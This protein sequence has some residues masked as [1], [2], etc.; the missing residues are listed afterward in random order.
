MKTSSSRNATLVVA[1][2]VAALCAASNAAAVNLVPNDSFETYSNCPTG[3][4]QMYQAVPWNDPTTGTSD[5]YNACATGAFT[6]GVPANN[7]G[8]Q[9][10]RTGSGYA[11]FIVYSNTS[12]YREYVEVPLNTSLVASTNYTVSF[13]VSLADN[14]DTATDRI[15]AYLSVGVV[16][17]VG[18]YFSLPYT[19]QVESPGGTYLTDKVNWVLVSGSFT[20]SGGEDHLVIGNFHDDANT[21]TS[22]VG[23]AFSPLSYYY[24]DDVSV[25]QQLA[26]DQACC[27]PGGGCTMMTAYECK[28]LGGI[29]LGAGTTCDATVCSPT[30]AKKATWGGLKTFYR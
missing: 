15:G 8:V 25:A 4:S 12:E 26:V 22:V 16:G 21:A 30:S 20:A 28:A 11:G 23:G 14:S 24:V 13:Y 7:F 27:T 2:C 18:N 29:P 19:P 3:Y 10:A 1:L 5:Y 9:S 6:P 17:P